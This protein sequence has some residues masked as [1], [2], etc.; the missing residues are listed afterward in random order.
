M[1]LGACPGERETSS[2]V[3][4][5]NPTNHS[6]LSRGLGRG[7]CGNGF[8][9]VFRWGFAGD[10][11]ESAVKNAAVRK[12]TGRR[13]RLDRHIGLGEQLQ[14]F[15]HALVG[16]VFHQRNVE[17]VF[18]KAGEVRGVIEAF[19]RECLQGEPGVQVAI[20]VLDELA[21]GIVL[22]F[23]RKGGFPRDQGDE[24][25]HVGFVHQIEMREALGLLFDHALKKGLD[26][27]LLGGGESNHP[28]VL[29]LGEFLKG[30]EEKQ[31]EGVI[32]FDHLLH[33][34]RVEAD[35]VVGG[36]V[37][38]M[39]PVNA[40]VVHENEVAF[41]RG[42]M[43]AIHLLLNDPGVDVHDLDEVMGVDGV[44]ALY[45]VEKDMASGITG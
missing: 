32:G 25:R 8:F 16:D 24:D 4:S 39:E 35:V 20:D 14:G 34:L 6:I 42:E 10:F 3:R 5:R 18:E 17:L 23:L 19:L 26:L 22:A 31:G 44:L 15:L 41:L 13:D 7:G 11:R 33:R 30:G 45:F 21:P 2:R 1:R 9:A 38:G 43:L 12:A 29:P 27:S 37:R 28:V 36:F 40:V